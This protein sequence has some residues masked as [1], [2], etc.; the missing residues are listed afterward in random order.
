MK[1]TIQKSGSRSILFTALLLLIAIYSNAQESLSLSEILHKNMPG[2][3]I[4]SSVFGFGFVLY[5]ISKIV[6]KYSK[7]DEENQKVIPTINHRHKHHHRVI[8]KSA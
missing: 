3:Y 6:S 7:H 2:V 5:L 8:K 1:T 4:I